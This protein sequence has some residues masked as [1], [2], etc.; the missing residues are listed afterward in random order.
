[1]SVE[2]KQARIA[3]FYA[4]SSQ[5]SY[6]EIPSLPPDGALICLDSD[7]FPNEMSFVLNVAVVNLPRGAPYSF[8]ITVLYNGLDISSGET[9]SSPLRHKGYLSRNGD[10][11]VQHSFIET[12]TI[13]QPG[14]YTFKIFLYDHNIDSAPTDDA[15]LIHQSE[16][17]IAIAKEWR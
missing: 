14:C 15:G 16:C 1:M 2:A 8:Y 7:K 12:Y 13:E 6:P 9:K 4:S 5:V 17:S 10:Y 3:Y 11:C